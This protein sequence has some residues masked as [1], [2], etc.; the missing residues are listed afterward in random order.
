MFIIYSNI[1]GIVHKE[2]ILTGQVVNSAH[3]CDDLRRLIENVRR[4]CP[5]IWR[6]M[7]CM[8]NLDNIPSHT[9]SVIRDFFTKKS[10]TVD[11]TH[12]TFLRFGD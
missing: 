12:L 10:I 4:L 8:L 3:Y 2:F 6:Q 9:S 5:E 7:N 11:D 1:K